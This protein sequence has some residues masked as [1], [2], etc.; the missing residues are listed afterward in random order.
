MF[1]GRIEENDAIFDG[2]FAV[3]ALEVRD[4]D[5]EG[6]NPQYVDNFAGVSQV[7]TFMKVALSSIPLY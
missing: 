6:T 1:V 5:Q 2:S 3:G 7:L 4:F